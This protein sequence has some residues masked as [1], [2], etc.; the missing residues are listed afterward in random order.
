MHARGTDLALSISGVMVSMVMSLVTVLDL[1]Q[2]SDFFS[3]S[4]SAS[5]RRR[6]DHDVPR[7][8]ARDV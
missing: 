3:K 5:P 8:A 1:G 7:H 4:P 6:R 2:P